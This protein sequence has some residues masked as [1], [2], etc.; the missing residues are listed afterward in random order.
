MMNRIERRL[1]SVERRNDPRVLRWLFPPN[2]TPRSQ[3]KFTWIRGD[4]DEA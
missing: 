1:A 2:G 3:V 4:M